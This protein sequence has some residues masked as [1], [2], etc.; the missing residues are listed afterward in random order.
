[1]QNYMEFDKKLLANFT[2]GLQNLS[3]LSG[4]AVV[5]Q[6]YRGL[7]TILKILKTLVSIIARSNL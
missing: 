3:K 6:L 2:E 5:F 4:L 1:M 7:E